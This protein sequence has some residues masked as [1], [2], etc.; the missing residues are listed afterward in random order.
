MGEDDRGEAREASDEHED[1]VDPEIEALEA[2]IAPRTPAWQIGAFVVTVA[3]VLGSAL[4]SWM[5]SA[6]KTSSLP[7]LDEDAARELGRELDVLRELPPHRRRGAAGRALA[8]IEEGRLPAPL[9]VALVDGGRQS[10]PV[11]LATLRGALSDPA[12]VPLWRDLCGV[13]FDLEETSRASRSGMRVYE[14]CGLH[15]FGLS[16]ASHVVTSHAEEVLAAHA[17]FRHL[18]DADALT[19]VEARALRSLG[20]GTVAATPALPFH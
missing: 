11:R 8:A 16:S 1:L 19:E 2:R 3:L 12:V 4:S 10:E 7:S 14:A 6:K 13:D 17:I 9:I 20:E 15:R 5:M 18:Q